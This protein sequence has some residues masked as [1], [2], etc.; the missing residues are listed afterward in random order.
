MAPITGDAASIGTE[1]LNWGK[2]AVEQYNE[3]NGTNFTLVEGD[4]QLDPA[5][6]STVAPQF[7]SNDDIVAVVGP[8]GSQEVDAVGQIFADAGM[9]FI[10]MSATATSLTDGTY[11]TFFRVVP[12]DD[13]QGPTDATYIA[14]TLG[15]KKVMIIDDQTSYSTGLADQ[16]QSALEDAG[17]KV[18][19]ESVSQD[20]TDFSALVSKVADDTD[21]VFLPW[22]IAANA[23]VFGNQLAEQGKDA[24]IFGSDGLF[25]PSDFKIGGS[26]VSSFA[27]DIKNI[28]EDADVVDAYTTEYGDF[29]TFG[30][31][32]YAAA[33]VILDAITRVCQSGETPS[34]ENVLEQIKATNQPT[35]ILGGPIEFDDNGD[36]LERQFYIFQVQDDGSYKLVQ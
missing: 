6:A 11:P 23:Q 4:T 29:G 34:R 16:A 14:E 8:A 15:A 32:T 13:D 10:S 27:P 1:Q 2:L 35:S 33:T 21:V 5:Q 19:R 18:T 28:P 36:I 25:S 12:R 9:P 20:Q 31:P 3:A 24:V 17:V 26:Y 30:P 7:V 22:Q